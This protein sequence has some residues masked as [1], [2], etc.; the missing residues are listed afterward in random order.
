MEE[1][2]WTV[3]PSGGES[4]CSPKGKVGASR[5]ADRASR[6]T[7][8]KGREMTFSKIE[9]AVLAIAR[10]EM[11]VVVDDQ[12]RENEGSSQA[13]RYFALYIFYCLHFDV[14]NLPLRC[15]DYRLVVH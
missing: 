3:L 1:N 12:D 11:V 9:D 7:P 13:T 5:C 8:L 14:K 15:I 4:A 6:G 2:T 10:G